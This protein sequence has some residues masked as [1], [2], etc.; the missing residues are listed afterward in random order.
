MTEENDT[1]AESTTKAALAAKLYRLHFSGETVIRTDVLA[2]LIADS[3]RGRA[4]AEELLDDMATDGSA[5]IRSA[6]GG[7]AVEMAARN[8]AKTMYEWVSAYVDER[9]ESGRIEVPRRNY[10]DWNDDGRD[11]GEQ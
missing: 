1:D 2:G 8:D 5:P 3:D 6:I 7:G 9:D 11:D 4:R 10:E